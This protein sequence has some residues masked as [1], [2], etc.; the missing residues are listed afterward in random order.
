MSGVVTALAR[1]FALPVS[2]ITVTLAA[3]TGAEDILLAEGNAADPGLAL[4][5]ARRVGHLPPATDWTALTVTDV[6]HFLLRLRASLLGGG[7]S[8]NQ[9]CRAPVCGKRVEFSFRIADYLAHHAPQPAR[10]RGWAAVAAAEP[11]WYRLEAAGET[12][13]RFRLPNLGDQ[14]EAYGRRDGT[15]WL[16]EICIAPANLPR[17]VRLRAHAAM[18]CLAPPLSS[19]LAGDCPDCG[20]RLEAQFEARQFCLTELQD[21]ARYIYDDVDVIAERYHWDEEMILALPRARRMQY[22]ERA[23][24]TARAT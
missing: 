13:A 16:E 24:Q 15:A 12:Q 2:G 23:R 1:C 8:A 5:L 9:N 22:A 11:G 21:R 6:D 19:T 20:A 10:G 4:A 3:L 14:I 17:Q 7:I 18:E